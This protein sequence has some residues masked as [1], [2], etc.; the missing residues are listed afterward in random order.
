GGRGLRRARGPETARFAEF[1]PLEGWCAAGDPRWRLSF[2][3]RGGGAPPAG[4]ALPA[5]VDELR[6]AVAAALAGGDLA[7]LMKDLEARTE[8]RPDEGG[9]ALIR[10]LW[11]TTVRGGAAP[12]QQ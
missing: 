6:G 12:P 2:G 11:G 3:P 7:G 9:T 5:N 8:S 1:A 4:D 10:A